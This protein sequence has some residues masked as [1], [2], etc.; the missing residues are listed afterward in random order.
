[1]RAGSAGCDA[2]EQPLRQQRY[3]TTRGHALATFVPRRAGDV[4]V[5]PEAAFGEAGEEAAGRDG[6]GVLATDIGHVGEARVE[7]ALVVVPERQA[8]G[9]VERGLTRGEQL[10]GT[11]FVL[12][13]Q[14]AGVLA[15]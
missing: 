2:V 8:P 9:A 14:A 10:G 5:R 15:Q 13:H 11:R 1:M 12:G 7:L 3:R 6:A 4:E